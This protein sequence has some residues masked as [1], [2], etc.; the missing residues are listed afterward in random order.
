MTLRIIINDVKPL[1]ANKTISF[2]RRGKY[3]KSTAKK[4][5]Q[6]SVHEQLYKHKEEFGIFRRAFDKRGDFLCVSY[7]Y[8]IPHSKFWNKDNTMKQ[9]RID[10]GNCQK[11]LQ[12]CIFKAIGVN[13]CFI[14][15]D[16]NSIRPADNYKFTI[17]I[18]KLPIDFS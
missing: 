2:N 15:D 16:N 10:L 17:H 18:T 4:K 6:D 12:D 3:F 8:K 1:S 13:D 11:V 5:F 7:D 14:L 9:T